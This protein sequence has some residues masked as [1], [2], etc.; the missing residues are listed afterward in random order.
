EFVPYAFEEPLGGKE[1]NYYRLL[2]P[3]GKEITIEGTI[4]R[5]DV[6]DRDGERYVRVVDYK[7]GTKDFALCDVYYGINIQMLVY[8]FSIQQGGKGG[9]DKTVPSG[10]LYMPAKNS[11]LSVQ[12]EDSPEDIENAKRKSFCMNGLLLD[13]EAVLNAMEPGLSGFYIPVKNKKGAVT[14][15]VA[16]LAEFGV[17][18]KHIDSLLINMAT[19]LSAGKISAMPYRK[20]EFTPCDFCKFREVCRRS[21]NAPFVEHE[22]FKDS[23]F[24]S[25]VEG[26]DENG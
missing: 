25:K 9:L 11:V 2:T 6:L 14:G 15:S 7:T 12:R 26:S 4:D 1:I 19:E 24:F 20:K 13:D 22:T 23:E 3:D 10:V 8:L 18:K 16:S 5:V 21:E 17:I